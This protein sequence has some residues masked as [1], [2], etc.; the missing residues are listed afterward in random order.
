MTKVSDADKKEKE[1]VA[2][3]CG[4][5]IDVFHVVSQFL[6]KRSKCSSAAMDVD[7]ID[8]MNACRDNCLSAI[9]DLVEELKAMREMA[10]NFKPSHRYDI[11]RTYEPQ[12]SASLA[13]A[14]WIERQADAEISFY[15][16]EMNAK[17]EQYRRND[18][19]F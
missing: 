7:F 4:R 17:M 2:C 5:M 6:A 1:G 11:E 18:P 3:D 10:I 14:K 12:I 16:E 19:N 9:D 15:E 13:L 8:N